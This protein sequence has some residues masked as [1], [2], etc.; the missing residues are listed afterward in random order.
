MVSLLSS[1]LRDILWCVCFLLSYQDELNLDSERRVKPCCQFVRFLHALKCYRGQC[2][3]TVLKR[4]NCSSAERMII[5]FSIIIHSGLRLSPPGTAAT[6]A[7]SYQPQMIDGGDCGAIGGMKIG[8]RTRSPGRKPATLSTTN[9]TWSDPGSNPGRC[10]GKPETNPP[11][12]WHGLRRT[13]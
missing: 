12:L 1:E 8:R 5:F 11:E 2:R 9:P 4:E 10:G 3:L 13:T 7:L 6:T